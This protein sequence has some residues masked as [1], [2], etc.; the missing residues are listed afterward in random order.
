MGNLRISITH[1][2]QPPWEWRAVWENDL[3][4]HCLISLVPYVHFL[5]P[6]I[7]ELIYCCATGIEPLCPVGPVTLPHPSVGPGAHGP[8]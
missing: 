6:E 5:L 3:W 4:G 7:G 1:Q 8:Q 2:A